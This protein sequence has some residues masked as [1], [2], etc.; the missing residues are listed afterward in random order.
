MYS[1]VTIL[2]PVMS[3][4]RH[5]KE[6]Y[7]RARSEFGNLRVEDQAV[8]LVEATVSTVARG[9]EAVGKAVASELDTLFHQE[10][11]DTEEASETKPK[12]PVKKRTVKTKKSTSAP[13]T[14]S[15]TPD[16]EDDAE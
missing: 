11:K 2:D 3:D 1:H 14:S 13:K 5:R 16:R 4:D 10:S 12:D 6:Q 9:I 15:K 8:F 7:E